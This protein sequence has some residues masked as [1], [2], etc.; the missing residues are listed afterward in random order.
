MCIP[1]LC[2]AHLS[3]KDSICSIIKILVPAFLNLFFFLNSY[4]LSTICLDALWY[5]YYSLS[6]VV[7]RTGEKSEFIFVRDQCGHEV[8]HNHYDAHSFSTTFTSILSSWNLI[9]VG[10]FGFRRLIAFLQG[11]LDPVLQVC[12][13]PLLVLEIHLQYVCLFS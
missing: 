9:M 10:V 6:K 8:S 1:P 7:W 12:N 13:L 3:H 2:H 5:L 4:Q 11:K